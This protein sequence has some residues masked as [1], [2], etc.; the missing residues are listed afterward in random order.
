MALV[1]LKQRPQRA[2]LNLPTMWGH[3]EK[4]AVCGPRRGLSPGMEL[5]GA[6]VLVSSLQCVVF[7]YG[8]VIMK[9]SGVVL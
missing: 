2:V 8:E 1:P 7:H 3:S 4:G 6:L 9:H 5:A